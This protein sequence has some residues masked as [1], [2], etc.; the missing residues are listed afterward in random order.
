MFRLGRMGERFDAHAT[1]MDKVETAIDKIQEAMATVAVQKN[2]IQ[3]IADQVAQNT[4]RTDETFARVFTL[5]DRLQDHR[6][7]EPAR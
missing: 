5:L 2:Q 3:T 6:P 4:K 1:K 7:R